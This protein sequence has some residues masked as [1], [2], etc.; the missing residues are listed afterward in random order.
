MDSTIKKSLDKMSG[1]FV[2]LN[3]SQ[4]ELNREKKKRL[5]EI[6]GGKC[7]RCNGVF[8]PEVYDFHHTDPKEKEGSI[9]HLTGK[10]LEFELEKVILLCANCHRIFHSSVGERRS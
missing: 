10:K 7:C 6:K 4:T 1:A 3:K 2:S 5:I 8:P 9:M